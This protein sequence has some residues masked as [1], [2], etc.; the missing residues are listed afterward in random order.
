MDRC[1]ARLRGEYEKAGKGDVFQELKPQLMGEAER[2]IYRRLA[3]KL[4]VS[5]DTLRVT[6]HRMRVRLRDI[7]LEEVAATVERPDEIEAELSYL[8]G[9]LRS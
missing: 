4:G 5:A 1:L 3:A 6:A 7:L 2:G 8:R 9:V